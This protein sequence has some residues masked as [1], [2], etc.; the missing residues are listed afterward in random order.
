MVLITGFDDAN[1]VLGKRVNRTE[2]G[3]NPEPKPN[4]FNEEMKEDGDRVAKFVRATYMILKN[5]E[6]FTQNR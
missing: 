6:A 3:L 2:L 1:N 5:C 4:V